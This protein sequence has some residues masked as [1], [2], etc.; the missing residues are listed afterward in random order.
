MTRLHYLP[1]LVGNRLTLRQ[2]HS[3]LSQL[4]KS[5][6]AR[7]TDAR[8]LVGYVR[9]IAFQLIL[10]RQLLARRRKNENDMILHELFSDH[11]SNQSLIYV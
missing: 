5:Q 8:H 6:E 11:F 4:R 1:P 10:Q 3:S 7:Q 9:D 2:W